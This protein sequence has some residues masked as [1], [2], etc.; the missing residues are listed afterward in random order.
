MWLLHLIGWPYIYH[1]LTKHRSPQGHGLAYTE[2]TKVTLP[3]GKAGSYYL[4][5]NK[6]WKQYMQ[7]TLSQHQRDLV[8]HPD[9]LLKKTVSAEMQPGQVF[10]APRNTAW[11]NRVCEVMD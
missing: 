7:A 6:E 1:T 10:S 8:F 2:P 4:E 3:F 9:D 5:N 11:W